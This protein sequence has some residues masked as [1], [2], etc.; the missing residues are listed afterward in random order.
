MNSARTRPLSLAFA[1]LALCMATGASA[2]TTAPT[3]TPPPHA[4]EHM[5]TQDRG[6]HPRGQGHM[7]AQE[8]G[9]RDHRGP[10]GER[11]HR[12]PPPA[13]RHDGSSMSTYERNALARCDV[14][15]QEGDR[16]SCVERMRGGSVS[17][18]VRDGGVLREYS[19]QVPVRR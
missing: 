7:G 19:E 16:H 4:Q 11:G 6:M 14:F 10:R 18:S 5:G 12:G 3:H 2:Q 17:G 1:A 8:R 9:M 15:K 13:G